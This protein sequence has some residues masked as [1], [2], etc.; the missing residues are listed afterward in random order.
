MLRNVYEDFEVFLIE[1]LLLLQNPLAPILK[2]FINFLI[3]NEIF[4]HFWNLK[5][6]IGSEEDE[7]TET[8]EGRDVDIN[9]MNLG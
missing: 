5:L 9:S 3:K 4:E 6:T 2:I 1:V 7:S 8:G